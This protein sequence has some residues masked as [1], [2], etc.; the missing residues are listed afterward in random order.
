MDIIYIAYD[1]VKFK[2]KVL[3]ENYEHKLRNPM[4]LLAVEDHEKLDQLDIKGVSV[5][6]MVGCTTINFDDGSTIEITHADV[7]VF[8]ADATKC[9]AG[10]TRNRNLED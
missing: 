6:R 9:V 1:G 2:D 5:G 7:K 10:F 4:A 3:C 8:N